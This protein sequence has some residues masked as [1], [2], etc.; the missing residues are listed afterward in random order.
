MIPVT[1]ISM[2]SRK[3]SNRM[4]KKLAPKP[5]CLTLF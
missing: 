1:Q 2:K 5:S 4:A 3:S